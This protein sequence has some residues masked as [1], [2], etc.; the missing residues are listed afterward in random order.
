MS[1][2][3]IN[4]NVNVNFCGLPLSFWSVFDVNKY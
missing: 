4:I 2:K 3:C 1:A